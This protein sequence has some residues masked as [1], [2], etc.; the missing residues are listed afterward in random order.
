VAVVP[1][2]GELAAHGLAE[3]L[4]TVEQ[5]RAREAGP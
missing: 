1:Q 5:N 4:E 2:Q 3:L